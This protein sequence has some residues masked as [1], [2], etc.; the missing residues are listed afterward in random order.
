VHGRTPAVP[1]PGEP[2]PEHPID[3]RQTETWATRS[4]QDRQLVSQRDNLWVQ[5]GT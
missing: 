1:C 5:G 2:R 4:V 3:S